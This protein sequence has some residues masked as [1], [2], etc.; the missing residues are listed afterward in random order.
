MSIDGPIK[1]RGRP[2]VLSDAIKT[3]VQEP[4]LSALDAFALEQSVPRP[5]AVR[6]ILRDWLTAHGYLK[7]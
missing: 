3:R 4:D 5:E 1:S 2:P 7:P 6:R